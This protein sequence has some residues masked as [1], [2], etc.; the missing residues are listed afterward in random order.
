MYIQ[1]TAKKENNKKTT[2]GVNSYSLCALRLS[3]NQDLPPLTGYYG[4][5]ECTSNSV[6][7]DQSALFGT[8]CSRQ[9]RFASLPKAYLNDVKISNNPI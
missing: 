1:N 5:C 9:T 4:E 3:A 8:V 7:P 6:G 2:G